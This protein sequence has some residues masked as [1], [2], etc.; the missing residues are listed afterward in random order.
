M[1]PALS[2]HLHSGHG[3]PQMGEPG[4]WMIGRCLTL[5]N[6]TQEE[7]QFWKEDAKIC[8]YRLCLRYL[9]HEQVDLW[10]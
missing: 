1:T 4:A 6:G 3:L 5:R 8:L 9:W 10:V 2:V 7:E